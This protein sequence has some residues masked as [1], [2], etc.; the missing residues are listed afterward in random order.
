MPQISRDRGR[1]IG[2]GR[3]RLVRVLSIAVL[4]G[5]LLLTGCSP[6]ATRTRGS[7]PGGDV[8]NRSRVVDL[9]GRS[10]PYYQTPRYTE[11]AT[12]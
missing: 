3:Q 12:P 9:H 7:G 8:G 11:G 4:A 2:I 1:D 5:G 6:E 10:D